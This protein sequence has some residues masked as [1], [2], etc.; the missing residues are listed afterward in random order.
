[1]TETEFGTNVLR[2]FRLQLIHAKSQACRLLILVD[3]D[4]R[5]ERSAPDRI[6]QLYLFAALGACIIAC[7]L[8]LLDGVADIALAY[9]TAVPAV[10]AA[11][12]AALPLVFAAWD[13]KLNIQRNP[14]LPSQADAA[15]LLGRGMSPFVFMLP[16]IAIQA[17]G[18]SAV[19]V[20]LGYVIGYAAQIALRGA[21]IAAIAPAA[22]LGVAFPC[23]HAFACL[24]GVLLASLP[25]TA[26]KAMGIIAPSI[27]VG[28]AICV[29]MFSALGFLPSAIGIV[30][31]GLAAANRANTTA[32]IEEGFALSSLP[33]WEMALIAPDSYAEAVRAI[34][35]RDRRPMGRIAFKTGSHA[36]LR[37]SALSLSR[38]TDEIPDLLLWSIAI[39]PA[40]ALLAL[41]AFGPA[42]PASAIIWLAMATSLI[43]RA[44]R[45]ARVYSADKSLPLVFDR[46]KVRPCMLLALDCLPHIAL[47]AVLSCV[48]AG[49]LSLLSGIQPLTAARI[50]AVSVLLA[51]APAICAGL[52]AAPW[53]V[54][55][56]MDGT[57][58][59]FIILAVVAIAPFVLDGAAVIGVLIVA[60][61]WIAY[62]VSRA[63]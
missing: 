48:F 22:V 36:L 39:A 60:V 2:S 28:A 12:I 62:A 30:E 19:G 44:L 42:H 41:R 63:Q 10:G 4:A 25:R 16:R 14:L 24:A 8:A 57:V 45:I 46:L 17:M 59:L 29:A 13:L 7:W 9:P 49:G 61:A 54:R 56:R 11:S 33:S 37:R 5:K 26:R 40:G 34:R 1:M 23:T 21:T 35:R 47:A 52:D 20:L 38:C 3:V 55:R 43:P 18:A 31:I 6:Y 58:S 27:A 51:I 15:Y 50:I 53:Q 32:A